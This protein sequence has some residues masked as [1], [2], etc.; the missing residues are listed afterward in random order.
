MKTKKELLGEFAEKAEESLARLE[1]Q[2]EYVQGLYAKNEGNKHILEDLA[3]LTANQ[4]DTQEWL[5]FLKDK[6]SKEK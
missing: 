5:A 4:K 6:I 2:I 1:I 3:N